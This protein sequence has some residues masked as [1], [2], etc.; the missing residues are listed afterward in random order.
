MPL[1]G[2]ALSATLGIAAV[3]LVVAGYRLICPAGACRAL[4][5]DTAGLVLLHDWRNRGLD[6]G[7]MALTWLGS[8][9]VLLPAALLLAWRHG[10]RTRSP[11]AAF[12]PLALLGTAVFGHLA[13]L[14]VE[15]PRPDI[16]PALVAMPPD[17]SFPSAHAMQVTAF[18]C[19]WLL[20]P[21]A[22]PG[23]GEAVAGCLLIALVG[24][25]RVYLQVHYPSDVAFGMA[26]A[27]LWVVALRRLPVWRGG[28][29]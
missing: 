27:T 22:R 25:S 6:A 26:A 15:R 11:A 14:A 24:V 16:F 23:M 9:F 29:R 28:A 1:R 8:L 4:A 13:K 2:L 7:F 18:V 17:A 21:G 10:L 5:L 19:A 20:R 12:V 3:V